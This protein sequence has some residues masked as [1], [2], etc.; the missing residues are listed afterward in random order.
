MIIAGLS[1]AVVI[2][3]APDRSGALLT[4]DAAIGYG[5]ELFAVPGPMDAATSRGTNRLIAD[6]AATLVTSPPALLHM[7]GIRRG[8][9]AVSVR[10]L[11]EAEGLVLAAVLKR[12]GSIEELGTRTTLSTS[13]LAA[14]L[15]MLEARGLVTAYSGATFHP[16]LAAKRSGWVRQ[17]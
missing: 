5:R 16:T 1:E 14:T 4:A 6:H 2:V 13:L 8:G 15:T 17:P 3:E 9:M 12:S 7:I 10:A 11:S